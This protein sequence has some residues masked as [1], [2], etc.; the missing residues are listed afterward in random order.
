MAKHDVTKGRI[1]MFYGPVTDNEGNDITPDDAEAWAG[2]G[3]SG[4]RKAYDKGD[5]RK[6]TSNSKDYYIYCRKT[7]FATRTNAN[8]YATLSVSSSGGTT[9]I[10]GTDAANWSFASTPGAMAYTQSSS[11]DETSTTNDE[12]YL[13]DAGDGTPTL[14]GFGATL[15]VSMIYDADHPWHRIISAKNTFNFAY[16]PEGPAIGARVIKGRCL[17]DR[18]DTREPNRTVRSLTLKVQAGYT[19]GK[20]TDADLV[21]IS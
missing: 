4:D 14:T 10:A 7:H 5:V 18:S 11:F 1:I 20:I 13:E 21:G 2:S 3:A 8:G 6:L 17:L 16:F 19:E 12:Q 9:S 15:P